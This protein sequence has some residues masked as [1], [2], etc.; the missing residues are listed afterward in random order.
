MNEVNSP[1]SPEAPGRWT[2]IRDLAVLQVKLVIDGFRDLVLVPASLVAG[3]ISLASGGSG[4]PGPQFYRLL[5]YG[6]QSER[7][8]NL[9]GALENAPPELKDAEPFTNADM[10]KIVGRLE[11]FVVDEHRR[12]GITAQAKERI[13]KALDAL[14]RRK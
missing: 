8:I 13:D 10:D 9:F 2:L 11:T 5:S 14:Q 4:G 12:G 3:I 1:N 7:W 6:R